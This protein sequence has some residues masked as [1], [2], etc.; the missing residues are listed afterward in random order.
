MKLFGDYHTHTIYSHGKGTILQNAISAKEQGL[1]ELAI[2]DHGFG[3]IFFG[4]KRKKID[5]IRQ[6]ITE[7]EKATGIKVYFGIEANLTSCGG[8]VDI[9][10]EEL[11]KIDILLVGHHRFVKSKFLDKFRLFLPNMIFK[12][13]VGKKFKERNTQAMLNA[14]DKYPID[15]LTHLC[16]EMPVDVKRVAEKAVEK[17]TFIELNEKKMCFSAEEIKTM[18]E[19]GV[20]FIVDS[21]AHRPYK[22]G[23]VENAFD[24]V[25]KYQ[26]PLSQVAN[27][28]KLPTFKKY[29]KN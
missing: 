20:K 21:D 14:L 16:F 28:D 22:V 24:V 25:A 29:R 3:H 13:K 5:E 9:T 11:E 12:G 23:V 15:I 8:D 10:K 27:I 2:T 17:G 19:L 1:K 6:K 26:I 7:A 4:V 18:I